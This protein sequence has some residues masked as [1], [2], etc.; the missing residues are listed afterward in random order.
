MLGVFCFF[1]CVFES[2]CDGHVGNWSLKEPD[3]FAWLVFSRCQVEK[4]S[5]LLQDF[6]LVVQ[7]GICTLPNRISGLWLTESM[8][9]A[10]THSWKNSEKSMTV[11]SA[12]DKRQGCTTKC[13]DTKNVR[14]RV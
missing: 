13:N 5:G 14:I 12:S 9:T 8:V 10:I 4:V 7:L 2:F 6:Q 11:T 3:Y 1:V